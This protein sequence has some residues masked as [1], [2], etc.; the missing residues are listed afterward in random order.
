MTLEVVAAYI[1]PK[2][3]RMELDRD[4]QYKY[5]MHFSSL[6]EIRLHDWR[7]ELDQIDVAFLHIANF[8]FALGNL[9]AQRTR[10]ITTENCKRTQKDRTT[11]ITFW[12]ETER[13]AQLKRALLGLL[14]H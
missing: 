7:Y 11:I 14:Y 2:K 8:I 5:F 10:L 12:L 1:H 4:H 9:Q 6:L 13:R 3:S